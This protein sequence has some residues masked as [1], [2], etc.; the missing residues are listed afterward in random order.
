MAFDELAGALAATAQQ[1]KSVAEAETQINSFL[2]SLI[3]P[4]DAAR[5]SLDEMSGGLVSFD[6]IQKQLR[7]EG[8]AAVVASLQTMTGMDP[9][10]IAALFPEV[11]AQK[12]F[13]TADPAVISNLTAE[14]E[15]GAKAI[16]KAFDEGAQ[17]IERL[18]S[19]TR[20]TVKNLAADIGET[21]KPQFVAVNAVVQEFAEWFDGLGPT[22]KQIA[23]QIL[24]FGPI[25]LG[26]GLAAKAI[27]FALLGLKP[28]IAAVRVA[29]LA[30][31]A[32]ARVNPFVLIVSTLIAIWYW[33]DEIT[34]AVGRASTAFL[35]ILS[36][37]GVPVDGIFAWVESAW[38][39]RGR[40]RHGAD[41]RPVGLAQ[42]TGWRALRV[43]QDAVGI[44]DPRAFGA[45]RLGMAVRS[46]GWTG[47]RP[48]VGQDPMGHGNRKPH[49]PECLGL[50]V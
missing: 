28:I 30:L 7:T 33:W 2:R 13:N 10:Q 50:A 5:K 4:S 47:Q 20:E 18:L 21:L 27:G 11:E 24:A 31:N 16:P 46:G 23:G 22:A 35:G 17:D 32:V 49:R 6:D 25:L 12:F 9:T 15:K 26:A 39:G 40:H 42:G 1:A 36:E 29:M 45:R 19:Q 3:D 48:C 37:W 44:G 14:V 41:R 43:D 8:L 38:H 34:A